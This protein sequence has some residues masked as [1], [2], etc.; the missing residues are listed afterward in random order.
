MRVQYCKSILEKIADAIK[1]ARDLN[2]T[3]DYIDLTRMEWDSLHNHNQTLCGK[4]QTNLG[5]LS[6]IIDVDIPTNICCYDYVRVKVVLD[7]KS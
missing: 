2:R 6:N 4:I 7:D 3:I 5:L 1:E